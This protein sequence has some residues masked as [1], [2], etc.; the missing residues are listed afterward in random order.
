MS[1]AIALQTSMGE[2]AI[3][4]ALGIILLLVAFLINILFHY[5][6]QK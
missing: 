3:G 1:T 4:I 2:F 6:Q 5:F